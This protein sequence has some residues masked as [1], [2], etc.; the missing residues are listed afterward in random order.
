MSADA[1]PM[2]TLPPARGVRRWFPVLAV[3]AV[4]AVVVGGG[5]IVGRTSQTA[6]PTQT[7][8]GAVRIS[9]LPGWAAAQ[10]P[11]AALPELVLT[12][13]GVTLDVLVVPVGD[14]GAGALAARYVQEVLR[15]RF[16]QLTVG[17]PDA[18]ELPSGLPTVGFGYIGTADGVP[19]EGVATVGVS[20]SAGVVFDAFAPKGDLAW[21]APDL[22][23]MI[24]DAEVA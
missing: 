3:V 10:P 12:R 19:I 22:E 15:P 6:P 21:A 4:I 7:V 13:G 18:G 17:Q 14:A 20:A 5:A 23:T 2:A 8:G 1:A 11:G 24:R 16:D 9:P